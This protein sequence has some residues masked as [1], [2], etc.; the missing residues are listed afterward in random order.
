MFYS[1]IY[2]STINIQMSFLNELSVCSAD[3]NDDLTSSNAT[4][5]TIRSIGRMYTFNNQFQTI[6]EAHST[7]I[8]ESGLL[9]PLQCL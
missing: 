9:S 7:I 3:T 8:N 1:L 6:L 4:K 2:I 5:A